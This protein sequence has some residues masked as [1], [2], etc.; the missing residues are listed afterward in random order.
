MKKRSTALLWRTVQMV[1]CA[2][3]LFGCSAEKQ[4]ALAG[5]TPT[6]SEE[7]TDIETAPVKQKPK[8][9]GYIIEDDSASNTALSMHGF[10]HMAENLGYPAKLYRA[11]MGQEAEAAVDL[12][13]SEQCAGLLIQNHD[14]KNDKAVK[15]ALDAGIKVIVPYDRCSFEGISANVIAD[16]NEYIEEIA[17]G[18]SARMTERK[19]KSGRILLYYAS[20]CEALAKTFREVM[21]AVYPQYQVAEFART[22]GDEA[23]A[24][25]EL[26]DFILFNRD[27]K[28]VYVVDDDL[29]AIAV[30]ARN[31]AQN[32]FRKDGAPSPSPTAEPE[33]LPGQTP[34]PTIAPGLLSQISI[35]IYAA[36]LNEENYALF[37]DNDIYA[38][39]I[40]PYYEVAAQATMMLDKTLSGEIISQESRVNRPIVNADTID[41]YTLIYRQARELF[42]LQESND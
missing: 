15:K 35:T 17:H 28:G 14:G 38:L 22:T 42:G 7:K 19:L 36:G 6:V 29:A 30:K 26:S 5:E 4:T 37:S 24:V 11:K 2:S 34:A 8:L 12:A 20:P 13:I 41:K 10:L 33:L 27:I 25:A 40:E 21:Q 39:C 18:L 31:D 23:G 9:I 1:L 32:R 3:L 16:D